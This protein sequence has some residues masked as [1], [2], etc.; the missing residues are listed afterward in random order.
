MR[1]LPFTALAVSL[2]LLSASSGAQPP[3]AQA[4]KQLRKQIFEQQK[5]AEELKAR[6]AERAKAEKMKAELAKNEKVT[7]PEIFTPAKIGDAPAVV[8][9]IDK[10]ITAKL[11]EQK[12]PAGEKSSDAEFLRRVYLDLT[13]VIPSAS[14]ARAFLDERAPDKRAKLIDELLASEKFGRH[15]SDVWMGLLVTRT[16]DQRRLSFEPL[17]EW[18]AAEFNKNRPWNQ[19]ASDIIA[20]EGT[21]EKNPATTFYLSNTTVDK[22]TDTVSQVFLGVSIQCA[23]CHDHKFEDWKQTEYWSLAQFF[24]KVSVEG[25]GPGMKGAEPG[26]KEVKNPN[27]RRFPLPEDAKTVPI[28]YLRDPAPVSLPADGPSR[29]ALAKWVTSPTNPYFAKA[30]VNRVWAQLFGTGIVTPV[31]DMGP[32]AIASHPKLLNGLAAHFAADGFDLKNLIR[33]IVLSEAYQRS[34]KPTDGEG[35]EDP[36][37]FARMAVKVM[38]PEQLYDSTFAL[39]GNPAG[40]LRKAAG[41]LANRPGAQT[42]REQFVNFFLA[43]QEMASTTEY[44]VGIP[45]ALKLMNSRQV[46]NP[47][48]TAKKLVGSKAGNAAIEELYLSTLSRKPTT[49][50]VAF[51]TKHVSAATTSADGLGDVLWAL[52]NCSEYTLVR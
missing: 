33:G 36:R 44:E 11:N 1:L 35:D 34:G 52:L 40:P 6:E 24:M 8:T 43:G 23:Q 19:I 21:Q 18:L 39:V 4:K 9:F 14:K 37:L 3:A 30:M 15:V 49:E 16:S 46:G 5:K 45:Q 29:P 20:A 28:R 48:A 41:P 38:T 7:K 42:P 31:D 22:M 2:G 26:V 50:E 10:E 12:A 32:N 13:G 27:R 47:A 17:R 25:A 51:M